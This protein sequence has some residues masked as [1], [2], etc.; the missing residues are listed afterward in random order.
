MRDTN[1]N[2]EKKEKKTRTLI[3]STQ[4]AAASHGNW[5]T[6]RN[7]RKYKLFTNE[8]LYSNFFFLPSNSLYSEDCPSIG[9]PCQVTLARAGDPSP[10]P[11]W[12]L[13]WNNT[14]LQ[15]LSGNWQVCSHF[16]YFISNPAPPQFL[17][18]FI[19]FSFI[20]ERFSSTHI[21]LLFLPLK[22]PWQCPSACP[23]KKLTIGL[24]LLL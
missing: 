2:K 15:Y 8:K 14:W 5:A 17:N 13:I 9:P 22:T 20:L 24:F 21:Y 6:W 11:S 18:K 3:L 4:L 7:L 1:E 19:M 10:P 16:S 12:H 23:V